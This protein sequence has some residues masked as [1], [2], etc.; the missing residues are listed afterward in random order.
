ME[1]NG[2]KQAHLY[3]LRFMMDYLGHSVL[4]CPSIT[5]AVGYGWIQ[6]Y[7]RSTSFG[8]FA[9]MQTAKLRENQS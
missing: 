9:A 6:I 8:A 1:T 3:L 5:V 4:R 2:L 7:I